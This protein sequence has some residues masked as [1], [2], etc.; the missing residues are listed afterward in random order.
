MLFALG[1]YLILMVHEFEADLFSF[2]CLLQ[3][4]T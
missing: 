3:F 2:V 1:M 4:I